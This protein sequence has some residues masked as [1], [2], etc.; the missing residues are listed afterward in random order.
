MPEAT[1]TPVPTA[2]ITA[3][4]TFTPLPPSETPS[5]TTTSTPT[6]TPT[7]TIPPGF[8]RYES[9]SGD[10]W[11]ALAARFGTT[12]E[13]ILCAG[14]L[15]PGREQPAALIPAGVGLLIPDRVREKEGV[16]ISPENQLLPDSEFVRSL[17]ALEFN[18][19]EYLDSTEGY[20]KTH[21]QYLMVNGWNTGA[22]VV[23]IIVRE[24]SV[25]PRLLLA[26]LEYQCGCVLEN[27]GTQAELEPFL[28]ATSIHYLRKDL[29]G[30][31]NWAV[32]RMWAGYAGWRDGTLTEFT[33]KD[34]TVVHPAPE[35]NAATVAVQYFFAFV[36]DLEGWE[37]ALNPTEG[38]PALYESMFGDP[39][40]RAVEIFPAE[41][42]QPEFILPFEP[43][44][45]WSFTGG[46]HAAFDGN[47]PLASLDF[48]P[49]LAT[50]GC[51]VSDEW[52]LAVADGV[53]VRV[54]TGLVVLDL[55][56][57]EPADGNEQTGWSVLYLHLEAR[58]R[59]ALGTVVKAG[60]RLGHPSCE[61]GVANGTHVHLARKFNG[62][63]IAADGP[64]PFNLGGW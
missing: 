19:T 50:Q 38:F 34:G 60:D 64:L 39:W 24:N 30:Q 46:P 8:V 9:Q 28:K 26:L 29:W 27:P 47:G 17:E 23:E 42:S 55:D 13:E 37:Q 4:P 62:E 14:D 41:V 63:W 11:V 51:V 33:L 44:T 1:Q 18:T 32:R 48:A 56:G 7:A 58:E 43:G 20:L 53:I 45:T 12:V 31:L 36:Y 3:S 21:R 61:G 25:N 2:S 49:A 59:V 10:T 52:V 54:E 5:P 22:E 40:T 16:V 6:L 35:L 15:C 57:A